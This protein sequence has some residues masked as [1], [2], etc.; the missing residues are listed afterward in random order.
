MKLSY[1]T[2]RQR[3]TRLRQSTRGETAHQ[4]RPTG[5]SHDNHV[6][7]PSD[8]ERRRYLVLI[9][10]ALAAYPFLRAGRQRRDGVP[11]IGIRLELSDPAPDSYCTAKEYLDMERVLV[12]AIAE[13]PQ[14]SVR[15][16]SDIAGCVDLPCRNVRECVL[17]HA[18]CRGFLTKANR[19]WTT[20]SLHRKSRGTVLGQRVT[21][22]FVGGLDGRVITS[23]RRSECRL[24]QDS[25][26]AAMNRLRW[27]EPCGNL[28]K[29]HVGVSCFVL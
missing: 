8:V 27:S 11:T 15:Q 16:R 29:R 4:H 24:A 14:Q 1:G 28:L 20:A 7:F 19:K 3:R 2:S 23:A 9:F 25:A 12:E 10:L 6:S 13:T 21:G 26:I 17:G 22:R 5:L 18:S